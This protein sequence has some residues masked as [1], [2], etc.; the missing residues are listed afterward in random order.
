MQFLQEGK[1]IESAPGEEHHEIVVHLD[2][3]EE[4][5]VT[6][7][8][9]PISSTCDE[10]LPDGSGGSKVG[11]TIAMNPE[12]MVYLGKIMGQSLEMY[13]C[14]RDLLALSHGAAREGLNVHDLAA[15]MRTRIEKAMPV[16]KP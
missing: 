3:V 2:G 14:L 12:T 8:E 13:E 9:L 10:M 7:C 11:R 15:T 4:I 1:E 6:L 5:P 16:F